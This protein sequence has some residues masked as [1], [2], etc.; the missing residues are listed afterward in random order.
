M[1]LELFVK[2]EDQAN[3]SLH[4]V[5]RFGTNMVGVAHSKENIV[6]MYQSNNPTVGHEQGISFVQLED[7]VFGY[8]RNVEYNRDLEDENKVVHLL[9]NDPNSVDMLIKD[10]EQ[11]KQRLINMKERKDEE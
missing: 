7:P 9:F 3:P 1:S 11:V 5:V 4:L 2:D 8:D 6:P 10:L